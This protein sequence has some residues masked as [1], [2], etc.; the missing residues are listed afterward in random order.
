MA[1]ERRCWRSIGSRAEASSGTLPDGVDRL[2]HCG[3]AAIE[4]QA[5]GSTLGPALVQWLAV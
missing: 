5:C 1:G 3:M 4:G 2:G